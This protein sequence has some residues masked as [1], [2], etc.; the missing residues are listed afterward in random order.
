MTRVF[1]DEHHIQGSRATIVGPDAHHLRHVLRLGLGDVFTAVAEDGREYP[2]QIVAVD[3]DRLQVELGEPAVRD[4]EARIALTLYHGLPRLP[5]YEIALRM[6][7]ELGVAAFVPVL[8]ARSVVRLG[9][10][11]RTRKAAR[12]QR[13]AQSA[14]RQC[15]RVRIPQVSEPL[16]FA[17]ALERFVASGAAGAMPAAAL[18]GAEAL[19]LGQ[20]AAEAKAEGRVAVF[21]GPES[22]FDLAEEA[23]AQHAGI[24]LVTMGP[25]I[26]RTETAAVVAATVCLQALGQLR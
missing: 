25:R 24:A 16:S 21:V 15:G 13:I 8:S 6:C 12:W 11:D 7:T 17:E 5:R 26:L 14:A 22:G 1:L 18:A 23:A 10:E 9:H 19:S 3:S 20:W 2:A 4:T